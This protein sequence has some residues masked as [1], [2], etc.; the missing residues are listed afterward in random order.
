MTPLNTLSVIM[1]TVAL[2][3]ALVTVYM[4]VL[5]VTRWY[6]RFRPWGLMLFG[7]VAVLSGMAASAYLSGSVPVFA[8]S[9]I[10]ILIIVGYS[11]WRELRGKS[12]E[13]GPATEPRP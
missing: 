6:I 7:F 12:V 13:S 5:T 1:L 4:L 3:V 9:V 8:Y 2:T 10:L 11:L